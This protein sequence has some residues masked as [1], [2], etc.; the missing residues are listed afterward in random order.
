MCFWDTILATNCPNI[1]FKIASLL[2]YLIC[3]DSTVDLD[4]G[5]FIFL[6]INKQVLSG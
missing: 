6:I 2:S 4:L 1:Q 3:V 5:T